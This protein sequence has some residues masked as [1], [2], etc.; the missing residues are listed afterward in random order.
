MTYGLYRYTNIYLK[1]KE[2]IDKK[3]TKKAEAFRNDLKEK[4]EKQYS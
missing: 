4:Y 3:E 2:C 1:Y